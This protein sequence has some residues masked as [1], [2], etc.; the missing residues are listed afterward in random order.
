MPSNYPSCISENE[1]KHTFIKIYKLR[2]LCMRQYISAGTSTLE[3]K[4]EIGQ[5][6]GQVLSIRLGIWQVSE[7]LTTCHIW[8]DDLY[9]PFRSHSVKRRK[10][11][12]SENFPILIINISLSQ[13]LQETYHSL[14]IAEYRL[15]SLL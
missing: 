14:G 9:K 3:Y 11:G 6:V 10:K 15:F 5:N 4:R 7:T 12:R 13:C 1:F 2:A 8:A